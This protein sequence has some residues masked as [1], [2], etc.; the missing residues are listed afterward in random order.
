MSYADIEKQ[1]AFEVYPKRDITLVRGEG[2]RVWD[3][4][5]KSYIDC[6]AGVGVA[7]VGHANPQVARAISEQAETLI[8]C[9]G[10]FYN[11]VRARLLEK[12]VTISPAGLTRAFLCNSGTESMEAAIKFARHASGKSEFVC[13]MRGFHGR[14]MGALSATFKYR[15][16]FE[17]LLPGFSFVPFNNIDKLRGAVGDATAAVVLEPVQGEGGVRPADPE[18]MS[19]VQALCAERDVLLIVDEIQTGLC[20]T[21]PMFASEHFG[22]TPDILCLAKALGGGVPIGAVLT[23]ERIAPVVGMHGSTFGG[24]PLACAAA[25]ATIDYM[26]ECKLA[27]HT[28]EMGNYFADQFRA[29]QPAR[30]REL[31][32]IGLMI[33]IELKEKATPYL[34]A[35]MEEGVLALS[36]GPTVIRLLP[37]L[38]ISRD[39]LDTVISKLLKVL[40]T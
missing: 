25:L 11:D 16:K 39:E 6:T 27:D 7:S 4:T 28:R 14:T 2:A 37:P 38:T 31:R 19:A 21:G 36:A 34:M 1:Y 20:R 5:G 3:D 12:L 15:D 10:I 24:N 26:Q 40:A 13:A 22:I 17:P 23:S 30:V 29:K 9:A 35:L 33:G 18:Y 8:T 32:Q